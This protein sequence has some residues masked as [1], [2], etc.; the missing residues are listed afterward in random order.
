MASAVPMRLGLSVLKQ[1][2]MTSIG[3]IHVN[4]SNYPTIRHQSVKWSAWGIACIEEVWE[5]GQNGRVNSP[6]VA[7]YW[8]VSQ[9]LCRVQKASRAGY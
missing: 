9:L 8:G 3:A 1:D 4:S 7:K 6:G 5:P 2:H